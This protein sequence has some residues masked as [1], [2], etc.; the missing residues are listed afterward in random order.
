ML[1]FEN[2]IEA[3]L[4]RYDEKCELK[5]D[6][7]NTQVS[8]NTI[9]VYRTPPWFPFFLSFGSEAAKETFRL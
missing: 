1:R 4:E 9:P 7:K 3:R 8:R 6:K 5:A 2:I